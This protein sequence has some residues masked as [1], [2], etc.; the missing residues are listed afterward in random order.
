MPIFE[1]YP[2]KSRIYAW[3]PDEGFSMHPTFLQVV[4]G[5]GGGGA[6]AGASRHPRLETELS[7]ALKSVNSVESRY[8]E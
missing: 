1:N 6:I 3:T 4:G 7:C 5:E 8:D 2:V